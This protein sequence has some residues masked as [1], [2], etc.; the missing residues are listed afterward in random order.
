M[1]TASSTSCKGAGEGSLKRTVTFAF[2]LPGLSEEK[3]I[4]R[5]SQK[6]GLWPAVVIMIIYFLGNRW[7]FQV[8]EYQENCIA[9][10]NCPAGYAIK[11]RSCSRK[12]FLISKNYK[13]RKYEKFYPP[14]VVDK[15]TNVKQIIFVCIIKLKNKKEDGMSMFLV[16]LQENTDQFIS[17][18]R[19]C[20]LNFKPYKNHTVS[21]IQF[22]SEN[23]DNC[24]LNTIGNPWKWRRNK[25]KWL[26]AV[27]TRLISNTT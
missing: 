8:N 22:W 9:G 24:Q 13:K 15:N 4:L 14:E 16:Q 1:E 2:T 23:R 20:Y 21:V 6:Y 19:S 10:L 27:D 7:F 11:N 3:I 25:Q 18:Y 26:W 5:A 12:Y 17:T